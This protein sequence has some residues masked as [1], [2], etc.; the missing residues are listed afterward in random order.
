M[1]RGRRTVHRKAKSSAGVKIKVLTP[2]FFLAPA[3]SPPAALGVHLV[4]FPSMTTPLPSMKAI[5]DNPSQ[6]LKLS[7]TKGCCGTNMHSAISLDFNEAGSSAFFPP[8]SLPIFQQS[9]E[10]RHA[11]RPH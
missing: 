3:L 5:R 9:S 2:Y 7:H 8:V 10:I 11:A 4:T 6:F 1:H